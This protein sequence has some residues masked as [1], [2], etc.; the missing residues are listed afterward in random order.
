MKVIFLKTIA[1]FSLA[2][3]LGACSKKK[4]SYEDN[5]RE[6]L[7]RQRMSEYV[8]KD[9]LCTD[10]RD[11][12]I[13]RYFGNDYEITP[14]AIKKNTYEECSFYN[15]GSVS[16]T[17]KG[18]SNTYDYTMQVN[19]DREDP[20]KWELWRFRIKDTLTGLYVFVI[21]AGDEQD[22]EYYNKEAETSSTSSTSTNS[23]SFDLTTNEVE[24]LLQRQWDIENASS[25]VGA[26]SSN[27]FNVHINKITSSE[28]VVSYD[29]RSTY[30]GQKKFVHLKATLEPNSNG[31][32]AVSNLAY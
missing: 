4:N 6:R 31:N 13:I 7:E 22:L 26:E 32:W 14:E 2:F 8:L 19:V 24:D 23:A 30:N 11:S 21:E 3:L 5:E 15:S 29:L 25:P 20:K 16:G 27:V 9:E 28:V 12:V 18:V 1:I 10:Y 17:F